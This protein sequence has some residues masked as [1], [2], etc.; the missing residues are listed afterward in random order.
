[1]LVGDLDLMPHGKGPGIG[2]LLSMSLKFT[3]VILVQF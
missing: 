1:M 2:K 3:L